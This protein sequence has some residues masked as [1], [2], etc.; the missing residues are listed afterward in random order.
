MDGVD[1][2]WLR[3]IVEKI[4]K[5][6]QWT[7]QQ[8]QNRET[9]NFIESQFEE[10]GYRTFRQSEYDNIVTEFDRHKPVTIIGAHYDLS[11][12]HI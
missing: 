10:F 4:S 5:P 3:G 7:A 12:I 9:A 8:E 1:A 2:D 6:R 11:L